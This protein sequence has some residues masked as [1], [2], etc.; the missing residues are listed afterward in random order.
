MHLVRWIE[1]AVELVDDDVQGI[2]VHIAAR[3][4]A[5]AESGE[6]LV[7]RTVTELVAGSGFIFVERGTYELKGVPGKWQLFLADNSN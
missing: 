5:L 1:V 4:S 7:S 6:V 3:I 2:T